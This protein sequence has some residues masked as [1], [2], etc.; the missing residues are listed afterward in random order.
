MPV[1][2]ARWWA[3]WCGAVAL[4]AAVGCGGSSSTPATDGGAD[5]LAQDDAPTGDA[6]GRAIIEIYIEGDPS[7][8]TFTDGYSGQTPRDFFMGLQ[9]FELLRAADDADP[10]TVLDLTP[11]YI[12]VDMSQKTLVGA[13]HTGE[14][15]AGTYSHGRALLVM[16]RFTVDATAHSGTA[17]LAG[18]M[19][20]LDAIS[21][22][23]IDGTAWTKG[24]CQLKFESG[25]FSNTQS[26]PLPALQG[27]AGG[28]VVDDGPRTFMLFPFPLPMQIDPSDTATHKATVTFETYESFR[29]EEQQLS[30][31][32]DGAWDIAMTVA[33]AEVVKAFGATGYRLA[34]E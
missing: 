2:R 21:D 7:P 8:K 18:T 9:R 30:G 25:S 12:E 1:A 22:V 10:V 5:A 4:A 13:G 28:T 27:T 29:W 20:I 24:Q 23:T 14:I 11:G 17:S 32:T 33:D 34:T 15:P 3:G 19:T 6:P 16:A 31:Y 26:Y